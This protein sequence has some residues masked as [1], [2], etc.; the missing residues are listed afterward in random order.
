MTDAKSDAETLMNSALPFAE[1]M[2]SK[3]SEFFPYAAA[4]KPNGD[5]VDV[6]G[7]DG[8]E[9]PPSKDLINLLTTE[10]RKDAAA[11]KYKA[12]AIV[13]DVRIIPPGKTEPSDAIAVAL[14]HRDSY[15]TVVLFPYSLS[16]ATVNIGEPFAEPGDHR[17]FRP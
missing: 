8:R 2:L 7:Y 9:Q 10:L 1:K 16:G 6:A 12:T 5:I 4:M 13:Y 11:G 17:I 14:E 15:S 3:H